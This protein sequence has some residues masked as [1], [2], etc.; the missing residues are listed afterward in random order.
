MH[1][2]DRIFWQQKM[3]DQSV[4]N[5]G[6]F[7]K[8]ISKTLSSWIMPFA[9]RFR[10]VILVVVIISILAAWMI[11]KIDIQNDLM[12]MIPDG[13]RVKET[14]FDTEENFGN[15]GGIVIAVTAA[16]GI[17]QEDLLNRVREFSRRCKEQNLRIPARMLASKLSLPETSSLVLAGFLQ[18]LSTDPDIDAEKF[19]GLMADSGGLA[20]IILDSFP[21][22]VN[23]N[24]PDALAEELAQA[25]SNRFKTDPELASALFSF[26]RQPTD[27][28][29]RLN[30][31]WVE[32]V[33]SI[34]ESDTV[35]PE[36]TDKTGIIEAMAPFGFTYGP[37]LDRFI[38]QL[39]EAGMTK[40][41]AIMGAKEA[42]PNR[43][44]FSPEFLTKLDRHLTPDAALAL[45]KAMTE[46]PKQIR[47]S[48]LVPDK[49]SPAV[50]E[51]VRKRLHAWSF[52]EK[53][54]YS[55]DEK[56]LLV[57]VRTVPNLDQKN[58][59]ILL[60]AI[61]ADLK[62]VFGDG[63]YQVRTAGHAVV[64]E[65]VGRLLVQDVLHLLPLVIAVVLISLAISFR[66]LAGVVYPLLTVL[67]AVAWCIGT[68][69][70]LHAPLS[71]VTIAL[72]V[73]MVAV[74]SAYGIHLVHYYSHYHAG[75]TDTRGS[76]EATLDGTGQGV[77]MAGLTTVAGF[78]S[79]ALNDIVPLRDFG[80]FTA[81][82][83]LLALVISL[84]L[85]PS[86]LVRFGIKEPLPVPSRP[87]KPWEND[88]VSWLET[89]GRFIAEN[90]KK[91][92]ALFGLVLAVCAIFFSDIRVEMNNI[93]FFK[94]NSDL[95]RADT[96]INQE[97]AGTVDIRV[98]F[99][100]G[101]DNGV[102]DPV[103]VEA[104]QNL[105][106]TIQARHP[107]IG[108]TMSILDLIRKMNQ[109][110]YFNAPSFYRIPQKADLAGEQS[111]LALKAH[112]ASYLD[113]YQRSDTRS[114]IDAA[115]QKTAMIFQVKTASSTVTKSVLNSI[116]ELLSG[117]LGDQLREKGIDVDITGTGA[118][119][120]EA[121]HLIVHGQLISVAISLV[122]VLILVALAMRSLTY[123][124]LAVLPLGMALFINFGIMGVLDIPLDAATA[125]TACVAIGIGID[126]GLH[127]LNRY[128][129]L[130]RKGLD[131]GMAA[132]QTTRTVGGAILINAVAV[133][134][135]FLVLVLSAF[136]PL[137]NLGILIATTM[138]T[139]A[140]G[141]LT[142]LPAA[143]SLADHF[144]LLHH[145]E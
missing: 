133:A 104:L 113:K 53:G 117:T 138:L 128:R 99:S 111:D 135:G 80:I 38:D 100:S 134:A 136:V 54:L 126:Y 88:K 129:M 90:P 89:I 124:L 97:F 22:A 66:N 13:N 34:T 31:I 132:H 28:R 6:E 101:R 39:L 19:A 4:F 59:E 29:G 120:L 68:M 25:L 108:K 121:E 69:S 114:F 70:F 37:D 145:K 119:Y 95:R 86:L 55:S 75:A 102:L 139:S 105:E 46:S 141:A 3:T 112:L 106:K 81:L 32:D 41:D 1:I 74:G 123:G 64:D 127:Y 92:L 45:E 115:K 137:V 65:A 116:R 98:L 15:P 14:Y 9:T 118:L 40:A 43:T 48:G 125:I 72:P 44:G 27:R 7:V 23:V 93:T 143:L 83:V 24:D 61:R 107:E 87:K 109:A 78:A 20:E 51:Q 110:F 85:I 130:R 30:N 17:F 60:S 16:Q 10:A 5:S 11:P 91:I 52:F 47:V 76:V 8:P 77:A 56:S 142:L 82:G 144:N 103:V 71:L 36:F 73:L 84:I 67:L 35:W 26:T 62:T 63:A 96:F 18:S 12:F 42:L 140:A 58:R 21:A 131:H 79:L 122:I 33:V 57:V 2:N 50:M 49:I 94:K